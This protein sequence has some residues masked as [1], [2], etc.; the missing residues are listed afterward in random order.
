MARKANLKKVVKVQA[1]WRCV[2][3][4][5]KFNKLV[6]TARKVNRLIKAIERASQPF[7]QSLFFYLYENKH[8]DLIQR[9][10]VERAE[11]CERLLS[12]LRSLCLDWEGQMHVHRGHRSQP[13]LDKRMAGWNQERKKAA[14]VEQ[15][16]S[17]HRGKEK[18]W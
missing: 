8:R 18:T 7:L 2:R 3:Q 5:H 13:V 1:W 16:P 14:E 10:R 12:K 11:H 17:S 9:L 15:M 6:I 4:G